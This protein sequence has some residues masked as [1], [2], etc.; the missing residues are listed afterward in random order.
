VKVGDIQ[1]LVATKAF[2]MGINFPDIR[3]IFNVG[4]PENLSL[5]LQEYGRAGRDGNQANAYILINEHID[6]KR[7][8]FYIGESKSDEDK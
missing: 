1:L 2:G 3:H 7:F 4:L 8:V 5:W 6:M